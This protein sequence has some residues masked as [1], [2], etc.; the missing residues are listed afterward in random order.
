MRFVQI[1]TTDLI[2]DLREPLKLWQTKD[3][4]PITGD[5]GQPVYVG[6]IVVPGVATSDYGPALPG[7]VKI[8]MNHD[9]KVPAGPVRLSGKTTISAWY[10]RGGRGQDA[11]SDLTISTERLEA[12]PAGARAQYIGLLSVMLPTPEGTAPRLG[13]VEPIDGARPDEDGFRCVLVMPPGMVDGV[14]TI[15]SR[16]DPSL[17]VGQAVR[18]SLVA[19]FVQPSPEDVGRNS[20]ASIKLSA[21]DWAAAAPTAP[22]RPARRTETEEVSAP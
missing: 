6:R 8:K 20:K 12:A 15:T 14:E 13:H 17:L 5:G 19:R 10:N 1:D 16:P 22:P 4:T 21:V 3:G 7:E 18:P 9:P 2:L 11:G